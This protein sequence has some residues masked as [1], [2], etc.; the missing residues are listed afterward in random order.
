MAD[1]FENEIVASLKVDSIREYLRN[2]NGF[3]SDHIA[4]YT[5]SK[6]KAPIYWPLSTISGSYTLWV[7]YPSLS[8]QTLYSAVNDFIEPKLQHISANVTALRNKGAARTRED[9]KQFE[10]Q[11]AFEVELIDLR[12]VLLEIAPS[13]NPNFDDG[14][15]VSAAPLWSLFRNKPWQSIKSCCC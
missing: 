11:Q 5:R 15:Q 8:S 14:V 10:A 13:Y 9:E 1:D 4:L 12:D 7:Y 3:F 6:R 2:S